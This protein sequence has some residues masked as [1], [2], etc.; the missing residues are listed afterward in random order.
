MEWAKFSVSSM[1]SS[2]VKVEDILQKSF[3]FSQSDKSFA[4]V[5]QSP[6]PMLNKETTYY[7]TPE[8]VNTF[9]ELVELFKAA[10]CEKPLIIIPSEGNCD[11]SKLFTLIIGDQKAFDKYGN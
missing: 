1:N 7:F 4:A 8:A 9:P 5:F 10:P 2:R 11:I 6:V 3:L